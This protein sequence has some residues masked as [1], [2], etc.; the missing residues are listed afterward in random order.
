MLIQDFTAVKL[1][2]RLSM[3]RSW[4]T[5]SAELDLEVVLSLCSCIVSV[6][7]RMWSRSTTGSESDSFFFISFKIK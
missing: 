1:I 5:G 2:Q 7:L 3:R 4:A 6:V